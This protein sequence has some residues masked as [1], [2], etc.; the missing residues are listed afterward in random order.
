MGIT[1]G[2]FGSSKPAKPTLS[3]AEQRAEKMEA[4]IEGLRKGGLSRDSQIRGSSGATSARDYLAQRLG[5]APG[6]TR[7]TSVGRLAN[8]PSALPGAGLLPRLPPMKK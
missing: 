8:K 3:H 2:W 6:P 4:R 1:S 7:A 5:K